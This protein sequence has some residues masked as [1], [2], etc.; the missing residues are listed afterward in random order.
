MN[1]LAAFLTWMSVLVFGVPATDAPPPPP[2]V[3]AAS[4]KADDQLPGPVI[5]PGKG[6][7]DRIY[8]GF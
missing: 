8:V 4:E 5:V 1:T 6:E 2:S 3:Q 7:D